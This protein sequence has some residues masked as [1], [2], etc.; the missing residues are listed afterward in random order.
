MEVIADFPE[1]WKIG[2]VKTGAEDVSKSLSL[3][4]SGV[5]FVFAAAVVPA[6]RVAEARIAA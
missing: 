2:S 5:V 1:N 3:V 4:V 6:L